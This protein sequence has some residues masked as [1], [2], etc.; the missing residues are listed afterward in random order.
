MNTRQNELLKLIVETF[1]NT[2]QQSLVENILVLIGFSGTDPN[3]LNWIGWIRDNLGINF[4]NK[5]YLISVD[6]ISNAKRKLFNERNKF[7]R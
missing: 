1:V 6:S 5:V 7:K 4:I 3:F 2:V